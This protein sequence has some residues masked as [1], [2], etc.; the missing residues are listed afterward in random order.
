[1]FLSSKVRRRSPRRL[2]LQSLPEISRRWK[3]HVYLPPG[4]F[5]D[6]EEQPR[7]RVLPLAKLRPPQKRPGVAARRPRERLSSSGA[8]RGSNY[9]ATRAYTRRDSRRGRGGGGRRGSR[10]ASCRAWRARCASVYSF[11]RTARGAFRIGRASFG[12]THPRAE[13]VITE[14]GGREAVRRAV[15]SRR[16]SVHPSRDIVSR[17]PWRSEHP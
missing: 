6:R 7:D 16:T 13:S 9:R 8:H 10:V 15:E 2:L 12:A 4:R 17:P 3:R 11:K 14:R 5:S 1:M